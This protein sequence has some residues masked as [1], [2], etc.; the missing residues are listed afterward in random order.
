MAKM[1]RVAPAKGFRILNPFEGN[2]EVP[3]EGIITP[4][5]AY[6]RRREAEGGVVISDPKAKAPERAARAKPA[7]PAPQ[8]APT[9]APKN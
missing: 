2:K 1:I 3:P 4:D 8:A 7:A 6:W 9:P 5:E